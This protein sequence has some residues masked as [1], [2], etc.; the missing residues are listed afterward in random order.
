MIIR[1]G[2]GK[3]INGNTSGC[4]TSGFNGTGRAGKMTGIGRSRKPGV[5]GVWN[6]VRKVNHTVQSNSMEN[7]TEG[8]KKNRDL[9]PDNKVLYGSQT[10]F[11]VF[12]GLILKIYLPG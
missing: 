12:R 1:G 4:L 10:I 7:I 5:S 9:C 11:R 3:G 8:I 6:T 2:A